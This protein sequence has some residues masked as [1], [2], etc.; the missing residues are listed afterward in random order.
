MNVLID[1]NVIIDAFTDRQ[2]FS[3]TSGNV[4]L[5]V[6]MGTITGYITPNSLIDIYYHIRHVF[7]SKPIA[8]KYTESTTQLFHILG[9]NESDCQLALASGRPDFEDAI[10]IET[11]RR[12]RIDYIVTRNTKDFTNSPVPALTPAEFLAKVQNT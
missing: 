8:L 1:T 7:H 12:H 4:L 10:L 3:K 5:A 2:P 9:M 6:E 11:A